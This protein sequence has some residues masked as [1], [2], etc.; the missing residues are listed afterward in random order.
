MNKYLK[1][2]DILTWVDTYVRNMLKRPSMYCLNMGAVYD[3]FINMMAVRQAALTEFDYEGSFTGDLNE[4]MYTKARKYFKTPSPLPVVSHLEQLGREE[5]LPGFLLEV[6]EEM[7][8]QQSTLPTRLSVDEVKE[9]LQQVEEDRKAEVE[10]VGKVWD[11][12]NRKCGG[13]L[14]ITMEDEPSIYYL[15]VSVAPEERKPTLTIHYD[16][17]NDPPLNVW[18]KGKLDEADSNV[19]E[20]DHSQEPE[21]EAGRKYRIIV[22]RYNGDRST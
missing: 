4:V 18:L 22:D 6:Y 9:A 13:E 2:E 17:D 7:V 8:E 19:F 12:L 11:W 3:N 10:A 15:D 16:I 21:I 1:R 14:F 5:E 20:L